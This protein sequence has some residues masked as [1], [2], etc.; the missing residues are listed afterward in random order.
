MPDEPEREIEK[1]LKAYAER[2]REQAGAPQELHPA[3]RKMLQGEVARTHFARGMGSKQPRSLWNWRTQWAV[4]L[5][6]VC[7]IALGMLILPSVFKTGNGETG[8]MQF[9]KNDEVSQI[10]T[11]KKEEE[12]SKSLDTLAAAAPPSVAPAPMPAESLADDA[13]APPP[14]NRAASPQPTAKD[15]SASQLALNENAVKQKRE[16]GAPSPASGTVVT[17]ATLPVVRAPALSVVVTNRLTVAPQQADSFALD[18][19]TSARRDL[20]APDT[21]ATPIVAQQ[22]ARDDEKVVGTGLA[23]KPAAAVLNSFRIEQSGDRLRIIDGDGSVYSGFLET[24]AS[25]SGRLAGAA[26]LSSS[27]KAVEMEKAPKLVTTDRAQPAA[28]PTNYGAEFKQTTNLYF[29]RVNGTNLTLGKSVVFTGN[30]IATNVLPATNAPTAS[31][32]SATA[33]AAPAGLQL[34]N[35]RLRGRVAI[36]GTN[37]SDINAHPAAS[38]P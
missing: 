34:R 35:T 1:Q 36:E 19:S 12:A 15:A 17:D 16:A 4:G 10:A 3:T 14:A 20:N 28:P 30:L 31:G 26:A 9:A 24:P 32:G 23:M 18:K 13:K 6:A 33:S 22:Y 25:A 38:P 21:N 27:A 2:R 37:Q 5:A 7:V 8:K 29:F 11:R